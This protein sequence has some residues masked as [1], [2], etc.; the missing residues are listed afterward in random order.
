MI[1]S[2]QRVTSFKL[3]IKFNH[4]RALRVCWNNNVQKLIIRSF[5]PCKSN[6]RE[7]QQEVWL[8]RIIPN[9][10]NYRV[11]ID[12]GPSLEI[13]SEI[14]LFLRRYYYNFHS[15]RLFRQTDYTSFRYYTI[16][17]HQIRY[18]YQQIIKKKI[19]LL[20]RFK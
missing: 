18:N 1:T 19:E 15:K 8:M 7:K 3:K 11:S 20:A 13:S 16:T 14:L 5:N 6:I 10:V 2:F 4:Q 17:Q 12:S 9:Y